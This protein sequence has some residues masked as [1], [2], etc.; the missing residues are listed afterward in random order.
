MAQIGRP[1]GPPR[2]GVETEGGAPVLL[3]D[4]DRHPQAV[5]GLPVGQ[6]VYDV[7]AGGGTVVGDDGRHRLAGRLQVRGADVVRDRCRP[8]V[9]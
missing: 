2:G 6:I 8:R 3:E 9:R 7:D 5:S 4:G 1:G